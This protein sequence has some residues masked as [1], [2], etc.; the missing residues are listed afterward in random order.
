MPPFP[1]L[2]PITSVK[3]WC[4]SMKFKSAST[5]SY[6]ELSQFSCLEEF[7]SHIEMWMVSHKREFSKGELVGFKRLV[8]F[9]AKYPGVCNARIGTILKAIH[10]NYNGQGISRSTFKRMIQKAIMIGIF[11]VHETERKNGSQSSNLYIFNR[12]PQ[13][14]PPKTEK[15]NHQETSNLSKT[16]QINNTK[17]ND[18]EL[19][20][21]YTNDRVPKTFVDLAKCF[22]PDAK[23]IEEYWKMTDVAAYRNNR[24]NEQGTVLDLSIE[25]FKQMIRKGKLHKVHNPIAYY[26]GILTKK[27]Y[28]T[29]YQELHELEE[30][31]EIR[32]GNDVSQDHPNY[33]NLALMRELLF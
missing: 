28:Q 10:E 27:L 32:S 3:G 26:Y 11:S 23:T 21:T 18:A 12:Y 6:K 22:F 7:N 31:I 33:S 15:V 5:E 14:E 19:D 1:P 16:K 24:E 2:T 8:R 20:Y 29:Y 25:S 17:R 9:A 30:E 4:N 13:N